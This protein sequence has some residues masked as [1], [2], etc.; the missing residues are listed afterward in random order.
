MVPTSGRR[1][2]NAGSTP[3]SLPA[4]SPRRG[5]AARGRNAC[6]IAD[7]PIQAMRESDDA[8]ATTVPTP[9]SAAHTGDATSRGGSQCWASGRRYSRSCRDDPRGRAA[10]NAESW[11]HHWSSTWRAVPKRNGRAEVEL[12]RFLLEA[13]VVTEAMTPRHRRTRLTGIQLPRMEVEHHRPAFPDV[14]VLDAEARI[15][16]KGDSRK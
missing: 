6:R 5:R 14:H 2:T 1:T 13:D 12:R 4:S 10:S 7:E 3:K 8:P 16:S 9:C 15:S 11:H